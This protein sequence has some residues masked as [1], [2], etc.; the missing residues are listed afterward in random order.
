MQLAPGALSSLLLQ[1][2]TVLVQAACARGSQ[3]VHVAVSVRVLATLSISHKLQ[4]LTCA[5]L[6]LVLASYCAVLQVSSVKTL[7]PPPVW[8]FGCLRTPSVLVSGPRTE[9]SSAQTRAAAAV[10]A[11]ARY[12]VGAATGI[13][14]VFCNTALLGQLR[15][16]A[17]CGP[18]LSMWVLATLGP[19]GSG[20]WWVVF[21][22]LGLVRRCCH[23][24]TPAS[25][26]ASLVI[27]ASA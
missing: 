3:L 25:L 19:W 1:P 10:S 15:G 7:A 13:A 24:F 16:W 17:G 27:S 8:R 18:A 5:S 22:G 14:T 4:Q 20:K 9:L 2:D 12:R 6:G 21:W 26:P 11:A 23:Y